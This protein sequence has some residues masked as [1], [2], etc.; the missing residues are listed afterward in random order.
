M[1][2]LMNKPNRLAAA[3]AGSVMAASPSYAD[4][5]AHLSHAAKWKENLQLVSAATLNPTNE[6]LTQ[7]IDFSQRKKGEQP[8]D[9]HAILPD[10]AVPESC[11][12][13]VKSW[14]PRIDDDALE[15]Q[16][17]TDYSAP[18]DQFNFDISFLTNVT[19]SGPDVIINLQDRDKSYD[20]R[21]PIYADAEML[22]ALNIPNVEELRFKVMRAL[23]EM[24]VTC[25][26]EA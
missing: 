6:W 16:T 10:Q 5:Q 4:S 3:L 1:Y 13:G 8:G 2:K 7:V 24:A 9:F 23:E 26:K 18:S 11:T 21:L 22:D 17:F 14:N 12:V 25:Q 20:M 15:G 19:L